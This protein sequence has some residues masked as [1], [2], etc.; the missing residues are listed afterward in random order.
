MRKKKP[1]EHCAEHCCDAS[2]ES[3]VLRSAPLAYIYVPV[4]MRTHV[5]LGKV[6][7]LDTTWH[8]L[9]SLKTLISETQTPYK[10]SFF[11]NKLWELSFSKTTGNVFE[12][13]TN[14]AA[15]SSN[16]TVHGHPRTVCPRRQFQEIFDIFFAFGVRCSLLWFLRIFA[17]FVHLWKRTHMWTEWM[18]KISLACFWI[19]GWAM[20][21]EFGTATQ[22]LRVFVTT[23]FESGENIWKCL[24]RRRLHRIHQRTCTPPG[25]M[26]APR[27]VTSI[28]KRL[29]KN[30]WNFLRG[31]H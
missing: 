1:A 23:W 13:W 6:S 20:N 31:S 17:A 5:L 24:I 3:F 11:Q 2:S 4:A 7:Q 15:W 10:V 9:S 25:C 27:K 19:F 21:C 30:G 16:P 22:N 14:T 26:Q 18:S 28:G 8:H 29:S 12:L